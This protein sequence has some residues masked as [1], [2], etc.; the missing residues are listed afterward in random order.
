AGKIY[1]AADAKRCLDLGAD[2]VA[3]GRAAI[4]NHDFARSACKDSDFVMRELPVT[5][6][7]LQSEGLSQS[8]VEY[9]SGWKGFVAE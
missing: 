5:R 4:T 8:F 1:S 3:I 2:L 9:M 7:I 6:E